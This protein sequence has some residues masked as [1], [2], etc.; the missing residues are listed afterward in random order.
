MADNKKKIAKKDWI[1]NF[2][3]LGVAKVNDDYTFK[4][5][6]KSNSSNWIYSRMNLGID[7]GEKNGIIYASMNGGYSG[8]GNNVIYAHGKK[9]D[10]TDDFESRLEIDWNDRF[11]ESILETVGDMCFI[12]VALEKTESGKLFKKRFL[13]EYDAI[14]Y[15]NEHIADGT[16]LYIRG[17]LKYSM[18][19]GKTTIDKE[20]KSISI[21]ASSIN[22]NADAQTKDDRFAKFTQTILLDKDSC[23][24]RDVDKETGMMNIN[25]TVLAYLKEYNNIEVRGNF[26]YKVGF[27]FHLNLENQK[28]CKMCYDKLFKVKKGYTQITFEGEFVES[29][30]VITPSWD[31]IPDD[32]KELVEM[33]VFT[34]EEALEKCAASGTKEKKMIL[35]KPYIKKVNKNDTITAVFQKFE[36]RYSEDDL[37]LDY[38]YQKDDVSNDE[39][40]IENKSSES[41]SDM[42]WLDDLDAFEEIV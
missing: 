41:D 36:E 27:E 34:K 3:L 24:L 10:G 17:N 30:A 1:S 4:I 29:G 31:D 13:S 23:N 8:D 26:P 21:A 9:E 32:I 15:C 25:A 40:E 28:Q 42:S 35:T 12:T 5:D 39:A 37:Y 20:I 19:N 22:E 33:N 2:S 11:D 16:K 7:C 14:A 18:Y 38:L 6:E